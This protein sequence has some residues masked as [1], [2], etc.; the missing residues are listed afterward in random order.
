MNRIPRRHQL[1]RL[2]GSAVVG[3][4]LLSAANL[5]AGILLLRHAS[6]HQYG[7][8]VLVTTGI[9]LVS[10]LQN[11]F[12]GPTLIA[13][14]ARLGRDA[15]ASLIAGAWR[16]QRRLIAAVTACVCALALLTSFAGALPAPTMLLAVA[17]FIA[18]AATL[19]RSYFRLALQAH[20]HAADVL[21]SDAYYAL[22]LVAGVLLATRWP[23]PAAAATCALALAALL[24]GS[25][26]MRA[27]HRAEGIAA[28]PGVHVLRALAPVGAW[29]AAGAAI[30]WTFGQGYNYL[31]AGVLDVAAVAEIAAA[32][33]VLMPVNLLSMGVGSMMLP[34]TTGWLLRES[35]SRVLRRLA[36]FSAAIA[37]LALAYFA[38]VWLARDWLFT[39]VLRKSFAQ[40]DTLLLLWAAALMIMVVR[41]QLLHL[42]I[43]RQRL[44]EL[45]ALALVSA[46]AATGAI[47]WAMQH[48]GAPG[49][50]AGVLLGESINLAG[51][52]ALAAREI[53]LPL[54][55]SDSH[56]VPAEVPS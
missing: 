33:L 23:Q 29:A 20:H 12:V 7:S 27:L 26:A 9:L 17:G 56:S 4:A 37:L 43:A 10:S 3:Q 42:L 38:V 36:A 5:A 11:A 19:R 46:I 40:R 25:Q 44:R 6:D 13:R 32:R 41:D 8:Y 28:T 55:A 18:G 21:K 1:V 31:V 50:V 15:R 54:A 51:I 45:S 39:A 47:L 14:L 16:E 35:P 22:L 49:A 2:L 30:H 48:W 24:S 34:L 53:R 52:L